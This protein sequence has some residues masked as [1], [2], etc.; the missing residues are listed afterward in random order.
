MVVHNGTLTDSLKQRYQGKL[1]FVQSQ[2]G[3]VNY[4]SI[5]E[6]VLNLYEYVLRIFCS[7]CVLHSA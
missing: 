1:G 4:E 7:V 6:A 5:M 2:D 3:L